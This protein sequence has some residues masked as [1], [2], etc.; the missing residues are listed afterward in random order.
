MDE[1]CNQELSFDEMIKSVR[2]NPNLIKNNKIQPIT[3]Y[4]KAEDNNNNFSNV[5]KF[6]LTLR[7]NVAPYLCDEN[8]EE[9]KDLTLGFNKERQYYP[10]IYD[11]LE[12]AFRSYN[13]K[14]YDEVEGEIKLIEENYSLH[15]STNGTV[16]NIYLKNG[17]SASISD[18]ISKMVGDKDTS[19]VYYP[20]GSN[21]S[22]NPERG[23]KY[24]F[25]N[26]NEISLTTPNIEVGA[27]W[28]G[29]D[30]KG[31][32]ILQREITLY[33]HTYKVTKVSSLLE[34]YIN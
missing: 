25:I 24:L 30:G 20:G 28:K 32:V 26:T 10:D 17:T 13:Y 14:A 21:V 5:I 9:I 2:A 12:K 33:G 16:L 3:I 34:S 15:I 19:F 7:D 18:R 29:T 8:F 27:E 11:D 23:V 6:N 31:N 4:I 22:K 1:N